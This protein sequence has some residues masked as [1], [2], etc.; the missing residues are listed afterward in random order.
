MEKAR[1]RASATP[2]R[3]NRPQ[4]KSSG[5]TRWFL[6]TPP[7]T[8]ASGV[9]TGGNCHVFESWGRRGAPPAL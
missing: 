8:R 6:S 7:W 9:F 2:K 5:E 1:R 3:A 4:E